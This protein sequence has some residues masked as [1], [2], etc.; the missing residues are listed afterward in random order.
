MKFIHTFWSKPL[1]EN[2]VNGFD[3]S[4]K[5]TLYDYGCS[6]SCI[7]KHN[8]KIVLYTDKRG[9]ELLSILP[10]DDIIIIDNDELQNISISFPAQMK[11][12]ALKNCDLGDILIDGDLFLWKPT[13]VQMITDSTEDIVYSFFEPYDY[14]LNSPYIKI[15]N[16]LLRELSK[17][18]DEIKEPYH[19]PKFPDEYY[20]FNT[21]LMKINNQE[22]KD[23]YVNDYFYYMEKTKN[24]DFN[25]LWFDLILEQ[26]F[27]TQL[28]EHKNYSSKAI[29]DG[30]F[31]DPKADERAIDIG[32]THL[33][34]SKTKLLKCA[35]LILKEND[36]QLYKIITNKYNEIIS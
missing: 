27:L 16:K 11:F 17:I 36:I 26:M 2:L 8:E 1:Y 14:I 22:L 4:L 10:Y 29:I 15:A 13:S 31:V 32:F 28:V 9:A 30:F 5:N 33:G 20:Y 3:E 12:Y 24:L 25:N 6:V 35:E 21:S 19:I 7:H 34:A 18:E 23:K